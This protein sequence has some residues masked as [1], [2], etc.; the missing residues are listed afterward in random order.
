MDPYKN[1]H[2]LIPDAMSFSFPYTVNPEFQKRIAY[3]SMEFGIHQ[4]LKTYAGGL[5]F[6]AGSHMRSAYEL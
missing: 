4:S 5:G 1:C 3:F 2:L 6:L